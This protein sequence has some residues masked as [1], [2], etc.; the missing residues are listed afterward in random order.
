[1]RYIAP[2]LSLILQ[3]SYQNAGARLLLFSGGAATEG[4]G[5]I[6]SNELKESIRSHHDLEKDSAKH[7]KKAQKVR[8][9][10]ASPFNTL[11]STM[12]DWQSDAQSV[13]LP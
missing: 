3:A 13:A 6:V 2:L 9:R 11:D 1:M 8:E 5:M 4:S 7:W 12:M 10:E